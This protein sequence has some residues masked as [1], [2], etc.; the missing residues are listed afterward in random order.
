MH[1]P[2]LISDS[3]LLDTG[4][5]KDLKDLKRE[6]YIITPAVSQILFTDGTQL[7]LDQTRLTVT[8]ALGS[9]PF[10]KGQSYC[11]H[12]PFIKATGIGI[13]FDVNVQDFDFK[14]WFGKFQVSSDS[15]CVEIKIR[16]RTNGNITLTY[17]GENRGKAMFNFHYDHN[18]V[19]ANLKLD[20]VDEWK[21][22]YEAVKVF[23]AS[24]FKG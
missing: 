10:E 13:N 11:R 18:N 12:L 5:I 21:K 20:F 15:T 24:T 6:G 9:T 17:T 19:L 1:N 7:T 14:K 22:N 16:Y 4:I 3:F 2:S 8:S 23:L